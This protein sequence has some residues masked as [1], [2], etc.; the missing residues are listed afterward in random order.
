MSARATTGGG[1]RGGS[2]GQVRGFP[3]IAPHVLVEPNGLAIVGYADDIAAVRE[4]EANLKNT[5]M[6]VDVFVDELFYDLVPESD[7]T[8]ARTTSPVSTTTASSSGGARGGDGGG[9]AGLTLE[10]ITAATGGGANRSRGGTAIDTGRELMLFHIDV[11]FVGTP[12][13]RPQVG[14]NAR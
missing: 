13:P 14:G 8:S 4:F 2:Q 3:G 6:F 5:K 12:N 11:Q 1:G 7:L 9:F 10:G